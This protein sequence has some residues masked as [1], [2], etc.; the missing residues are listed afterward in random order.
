ME[1]SHSQPADN[2]DTPVTPVAEFP[3]KVE[4]TSGSAARAI[5]DQVAAATV[6]AE[7]LSS[8]IA[9]PTPERKSD[10]SDPSDQSDTVQSR[11]AKST[12][13]GP[14]NDP[15]PLVVLLMARPEIKSVSDLANKEIAIEDNQSESD[16]NVQKAI[17]AAGATE[18]R[19][20]DG[21]TKAIDRLLSGEVPAAVLTLVSPEAAAAFPDIA[22]FKVFR[23][24]SSATEKARL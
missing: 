5:R 11:N 13:S 12:A 16:A 23:I 3:K 6:L 17:A 18:A 24:P 14:S 7:R 19:L 20:S 8:P 1:L 2:A 15:A 22:G 10:T 4:A 21:H 9:A